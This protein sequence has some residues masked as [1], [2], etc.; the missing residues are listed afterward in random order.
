MIMA[1]PRKQMC[2]CVIAI[3]GLVG[4]ILSTVGGPITAQTPANASSPEFE[5]ASVRQVKAG[6]GY[7]TISPP[8]TAGFSARNVSMKLLLELAYGVDDNQ[9]S[10]KLTWLDSEYYDVVAK[11]GRETALSPEELRS[12]LQRLLAERFEVAVHREAKDVDG[13]A[14][15]VAKG[16]PKLKVSRD[17]PSTG[18]ILPDGIQSSSM[19]MR[20][21]AGTLAHPLGK[22]VSDKTSIPGNFEVIFSFAPESATD[23]ALPSI[24]TALEDQL[25]LR[26]ERQ[27]VS[28]ELLVVDHVNKVPSEN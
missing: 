11:S 28:I 2:T 19:S 21:L 3:G 15:V 22:P 10:T 5:V 27:K 7:T 23:S 9:I 13:Y 26:L 8:G 12:M 25:G 14:L 6:T 1:P 17:P 24:F 20:T 18:Y 4:L 16:G